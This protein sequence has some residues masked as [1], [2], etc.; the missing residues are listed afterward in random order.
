[1]PHT[2]KLRPPLEQLK[3][4]F[5]V[6]DSSSRQVDLI[7]LGT[8]AEEGTKRNVWLD[9][10]DEHVVLIVGKRGS[11]KSYSMGVFL[12]G[13]GVSGGSKSRISQVRDS[14]G[15]VLFDTLGI[16]WSMIHPVESDGGPRH[17]EQWKNM[18]SM[19]LAPE[20]VRVNVWVPAGKKLPGDHE[21]FKEFR[22]KVS[23]LTLDDWSSIL[24]TDLVASQVGQLL[25]TCFVKVTQEDGRRAV[26]RSRPGSTMRFLTCL[27][28]LTMAPR[29]KV[30]TAQER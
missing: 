23:D 20:P 5:Y 1:M 10:T 2:F 17:S 24:D 29:G 21:S 22:I 9:A 11:G 4:D 13:L 26:S 28:A 6:G 25:S 8:I 16:F 14:R 18:Q 19:G 12:E 7:L 27:I 3:T 15:V 30:V